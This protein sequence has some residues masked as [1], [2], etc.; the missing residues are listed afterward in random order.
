V[1]L[2]DR[3]SIRGREQGPSYLNDVNG[4]QAGFARPGTVLPRQASAH[5]LPQ[6]VGDGQPRRI[7]FL[8]I[9]ALLAVMTDA[10]WSVVGMPYSESRPS[11]A[12][13]ATLSRIQRQ[14]G[15]KKPRQPG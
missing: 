7:L 13:K 4:N 8:A 9:L 5:R 1:L 2:V 14:A 12:Q 15:V 6:Q 3:L 10:E 11:S